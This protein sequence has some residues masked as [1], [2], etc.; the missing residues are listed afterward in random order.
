MKSLKE[1]CRE[2]KE[3]NS[4]YYVYLLY[5][6]DNTPFYVGKGTRR[7]DDYQRVSYHEYEAGLEHPPRSNPYT[8]EYKINT[9][10]KIRREGG[11]ILYEVDSWHDVEA[12]AYAREM[13]LIA[14]L[15]RKWKDEGVL[16]NITEGGEKE[17]GISEET[18]ERISESLKLYFKNNPEAL[19]KMSERAKEQFSNPEVRA[20]LRDKAIQ[21]EYHKPLVKWIKDNPD[22][23]KEKANALVAKK[24]Q[25]EQDC[26]EEAKA[27]VVRRN[28][29]LRS[30]DHR[31]H[32]AEATREFIKNNPEADKARRRQVKETFDHKRSV[33]QECLKLVRDH[34]IAA[35]KVKN[36]DS[37]KA[38]TPEAIYKWKKRG[39][40]SSLAPPAGGATI[41]EWSVF[42]KQLKETGS[43]YDE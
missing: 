18:R 5:R 39:L 21:N 16:T 3:S 25:W 26:P 31:K 24:L 41:Q 2:I 32:M 7:F 34:L 10:R 20:R 37:D 38:V 27:M 4:P 17:G 8:N 22:A 29:K 14:T 33:K 35:G 28:E 15:G 30:G 19:Q 43:G 23:V 11:C 13:E 9:I 36:V 40:F 1:V 12:D 42:L 6:P